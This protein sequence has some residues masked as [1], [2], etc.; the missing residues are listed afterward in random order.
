MSQPEPPVVHD[1]LLLIWSEDRV[2]SIERVRRWTDE[3][4]SLVAHYA[5]AKHAASLGRDVAVPPMPDVLRADDT[6]GLY[7]KYHVQKVDGTTDPDAEY[8]VLRLDTDRA[9]RHA[10]RA[11]AYEAERQG[12]E[13]LAE[14]LRALVDQLEDQ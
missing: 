6:H 11:Y 9:A 3:E 4:R 10:V 13:K 5:T 2:P 14:D 1:L 7:D 8:F 12:E